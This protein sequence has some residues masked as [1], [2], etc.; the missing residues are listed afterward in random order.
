MSLTPTPTTH[1]EAPT[2]ALAPR[3]LETLHHIASGCTY[4]QAARQ[5]GLSPHTIDAYLRRIRTKLNINTTA[6]LTRW[7]ISVGL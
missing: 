7:A 3:E 2:P 4:L 6:E 1:T 5:M